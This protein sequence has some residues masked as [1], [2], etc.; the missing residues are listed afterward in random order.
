MK[1]LCFLLFFVLSSQNVFS[2]EEENDLGKPVQ[3]I[4]DMPVYKGCE[5]NTAELKKCFQQKL[6]EHFSNHFR[7]PKRAKKLGV[8]GRFIVVFEI[9]VEGQLNV[10]EVKGPDQ[11]QLIEME[12]NRVFSNFPKVIPGKFIG[13]PV[14]VKYSMPINLKLD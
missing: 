11:D 13:K 1:N 6:T 7:Y 3:I 5:G 14:A 12:I 8:R 10:K 2:Q 4:E 9:D